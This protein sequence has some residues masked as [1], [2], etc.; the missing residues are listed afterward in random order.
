MDEKNPDQGPY[1]YE[2][3][4]VPASVRNIATGSMLVAGFVYITSQIV[5]PGVGEI[6]G[7]VPEVLGID[8]NDGG[9]SNADAA[10]RPG[11]ANFGSGS[12]GFNRA[13]GLGP[14]SG[15]VASEAMTLGKIV[16]SPLASEPTWGNESAATSATGGH[17][18]SPSGNVTSPTSAN[19]G[20]GGGSNPGNV[21]SPTSANGGGGED[22]NDRETESGDGNDDKGGEGKD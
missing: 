22:G 14:I 1:I 6:L 3:P 2:K 8:V 19:G 21:T 5:T 13:N 18:G 9:Q 16:S 11:G 7:F 4:R 10:E 17:S 15:L 20:S 12:A